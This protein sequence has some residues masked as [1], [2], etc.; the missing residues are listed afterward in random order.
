M[1]SRSS[2]SERMADRIRAAPLPD[3]PLYHY[4]GQ[5]GCIGIMQTQCIW[6]TSI[7]FFNDEKEFTLAHDRIWE[8]LTEFRETEP[9][10]DW[11][12]YNRLRDEFSITAAETFVASFSA[13]RNR[14]SQWRGYGAN[15]YALGF[16][17]G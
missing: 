12:F 1:T 15:G 8:L 14:L 5:A 11:S 4:T 2:P 10:E 17:A 7:R 3:G 16:D 13:S 6:A 9:E